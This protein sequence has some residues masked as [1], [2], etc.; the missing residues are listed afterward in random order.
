MV[1]KKIGDSEKEGKNW[2]IEGFPRN[3][4][5]ALMVGKLGIIPDKMILLKTTHDKSTAKIK[6]NLLEQDPNLQ[7]QDLEAAIRNIH[8]EYSLN[9]LGVQE[10]FKSFLFEVDTTKLEKEEVEANLIS[11]LGIR[12]SKQSSRRPPKIVI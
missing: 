4:N 9:I 3:K 11:M 7:S 12:F 2:I 1:K 8:Q 6:Q 5:Q 10:V